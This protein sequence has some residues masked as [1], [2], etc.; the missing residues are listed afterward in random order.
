[1]V[2]LFPINFNKIV[3]IIQ[4]VELSEAFV[5]SIVDSASDSGVLL[6]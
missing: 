1:M 5:D 4:G 2:G 3:F 6:S